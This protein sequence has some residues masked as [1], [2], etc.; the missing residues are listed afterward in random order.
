MTPEIYKAAIANI[1]SEGMS[2]TQLL[3]AV[4]EAGS[5]WS[6]EQLHLMLDCMVGVEVSDQGGMWCISTGQRSPEEELAAAI[7]QV[8]Q[9]QGGRPLPAAKVLELLPDRFTTSE[10]QVRKVAKESARLNV[11]GPGMIAL[12]TN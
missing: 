4:R 1:G 3:A 12:S 7:E 5:T 8:V 11:L 2:L 10:A 6:A 9:S